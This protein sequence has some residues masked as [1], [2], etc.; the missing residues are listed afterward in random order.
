MFATLEAMT[1]KFGERELIGLT[2]NEKPYQ[3]VINMD[4][5]N[6]AMDEANSEIEGYIAARYSLP[7]QTVPPF[8]KSLAC[9]MARY[10]A[11]T[12]TMSDNDPI[13][14]RYE[15]AVKSLKEIS[16]GTIA[17]GGSPVG[18]STPVKT[19]NNSVVMNIGRHDFGGHGW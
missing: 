10:H 7:L 2:D 19:S 9:H 11:C 3:D 5:L 15:N 4:K 13:K 12:G 6:A 1:E 16:K 8:L 14:T 17:L 18:E